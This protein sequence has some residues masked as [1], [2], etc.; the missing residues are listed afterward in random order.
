MNSELDRTWMKWVVRLSWNG[1]GETEK[2][3]K[4]SISITGLETEIRCYYN[5]M[6]EVSRR[7]GGRHCLHL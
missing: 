1:I 6:Q 7:F 4:G 5:R 3:F 2:S